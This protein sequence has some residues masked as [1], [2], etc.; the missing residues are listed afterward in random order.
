MVCRLYHLALLVLATTAP[1]AKAYGIAGRELDADGKLPALRFLHIPKTGT[2]FILS[3]RNY[4]TVCEVKDKICSGEHGGSDPR[5]R[6]PDGTPEYVENCYGRLEACSKT[7]Y[8]M[9][10]RS[11]PHWNYVTLLRRPLAQVV[12]GLLYTN[13]R[14]RA[15]GEP[16]VSAEDFVAEYGNL[17]VKVGVPQAYMHSTQRSIRCIVR[18]SLLELPCCSDQRVMLTHACPT[19]GTRP[20]ASSTRS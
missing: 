12:S 8:H 17:Q 2:S 16:E 11:S 4:L 7:K 15:K 9:R 19:T 1:L 13:G 14:L 10:F 18:R 5:L 20:C 3:L 6:F